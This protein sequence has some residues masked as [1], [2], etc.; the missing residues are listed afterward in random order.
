MSYKLGRLPATRPAALADLATYAEGRLPP[1][2]PTMAVP[3]IDFPIDG[4]DQYGDCT[5]AGVAHLIAAWN[6]ETGAHDT[7]PDAA[8]VVAEYFKLTDGED[9]GLNEANVLQTWHR[10]GLFGQKIAGYAPVNPRD[11]LQLHQSV[12]FYGACYLGIEC[13]ASAQEQFAAGEPWTYTGSPVEGG[14][15]VVALGYGPNGGL[16][17]ATWGGIAVLEAGFLAHYLDKAWCVLPHQMVEKRGDSLGL[18]IQT[19]QADLQLV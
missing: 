7:V 1:P 14:H 13:P 5:M 4:N 2:P 16:H 15:C 12:A 6:A 17:C 8:A 18:N 10:T 19:L 9:S 3:H 11:L